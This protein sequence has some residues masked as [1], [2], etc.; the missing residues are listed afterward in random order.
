MTHSA[1]DLPSLRSWTSSSSCLTV[2]NAISSWR[3]YS[4]QRLMEEELLDGRGIDYPSRH[5][6][7]TF[8]R[9]QRTE[10]SQGEQLSME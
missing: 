10:K 1:E 2:R 6:N 8:K 4:L 3:S 7:V 5:N 9:A